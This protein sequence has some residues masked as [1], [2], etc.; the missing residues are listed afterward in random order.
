MSRV[1]WGVDGFGR[2]HY[3]CDYCELV[4]GDVDLESI[5]HTCDKTK[6]RYHNRDIIHIPDSGE[7]QIEL[8]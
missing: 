5:I 7:K 1:A 6:P 8:F 2:R 4:F 3:L